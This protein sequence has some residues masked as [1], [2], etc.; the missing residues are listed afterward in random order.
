[1]SVF[2]VGKLHSVNSGLVFFDQIFDIHSD[3]L[4]LFQISTILL[5]SGGKG[6]ILMEGII[7]SHKATQEKQYFSLHS[8]RNYVYRAVGGR[9]C[10]TRAQKVIGEDLDCFSVQ[11]SGTFEIRMSGS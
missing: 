8:L 10:K 1:M 2:R 3:R 5:F 9:N 7:F 6:N 11:N 4:F